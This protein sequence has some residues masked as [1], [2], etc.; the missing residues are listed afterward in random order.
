MLFFR[1]AVA[2]SDFRINKI[3][4]TIQT[5]APAA[6]SLHVEFIHFANLREELNPDEKFRLENLLQYGQMLPQPKTNG[7][8]L[9]TIPRPGTISPWSSKAT[10]IIHNCGIKKI[11][12]IER[13][14][15]WY[16]TC[17]E[18]PTTEII[19]KIKVK[20]HDRMT[21][22]VVGDFKQAEL[23]FDEMEPAQLGHI[24]ILNSGQKAL[25]DANSN[26]GLALSDDEITFLYENFTALQRN[27]TDVELMMFAQANSEHCRHKIFN[28]EWSINSKTMDSSLFEMIRET[29]KS[30]P[31]NILSAY[32]DNAAVTSGYSATRFFPNSVNHHYQT[33]KED[34]NILMKV[35]THNHPTAISPYPGASTGSGGEIR[36]ESAT[37]RGAKPKAGLTGFTVSNLH[38]PDFPQPWEIDNGKPERIVSALEIMLEGPIGGASYNNEFGR[39]ALCGYFRCYEQ[40]WQ[41]IIYGYHKP[42]MLA[43]GYGMIRKQHINKNNIPPSAKI[44]V[45]GGPAMLIGLGGGAASSMASGKSDE[46]LDFASVQRD[47]PEMQR[48]CQEVIDACW[49]LNE[50]NPIISIHDVGAGGL[51]NAL[52]ELVSASE[53]GAAFELRNIPNAETGMSPMEIWCNEA[54]ERYVLAIKPETIEI[55]SQFCKRERAPF[56]IL[57]ETTNDKRLILEDEL[58]DNKPIDIPLS[59]IFGKLPRMK[60]KVTHN[61]SAYAALDANKIDIKEA[62]K[63]IL[64]LPTVAD[65]RFLITISDRT[66]SGLVARDQMVGPWQTPVAD[67]AI[68]SS[69]FDSY[70]GEAM[71]IGERTPLALINASAA[72]RMAIGEAITNISAARIMKLDDIVLSANWMAACDN[73]DQDARLFAA[74]QAVSQLC[75]SL[76]ICIPVGKDS[77]SMNTVW[78]EN[79]QLKRVT[80]PVSLII[81]AIAPVVDVRQNLTPQLK[82]NKGETVLLLIDLGLGKNRI[83]GS[84][85]TQVYNHIGS[86]PPDIDDVENLKIF[87]RGIQILNEM[88][89]LLSYHDRSDGGLFVTLCEMAFTSRSGLDITLDDLGSDIH[90]IVFNEELGAVIQIQKD[91]VE[92]VKEVFRGNDLANH[93][94]EIGTLNQNNI[95][96]ISYHDDIA[97]SEDI[98]ALHRLWSETSFHMQSMR[99]N[100]DCAKE[101]YETFSNNDDPGLS[102]NATFKIDADLP[103]I[104]HQARPPIAILREQGVNGQNEMAAAFDRAGFDCIDVHM[105]DIINGKMTLKNF[106]GL[107]ACGGFSYGDVLGAG[108]GWAKSILYNSKAKNEFQE[109]FQRNDTFGLGVCNGCQMF[110]YLRDMIPGAEYWPDFTRNRSEQ[111]EARLVM[112]EVTDSPSILLEGMTGSL[113]P[114]VVAHGEGQAKFKS[115][116]T[117]NKAHS[118]MRYVDHHGNPADVYPLNP[119]GSPGGVTGFTTHDGRFTIMMPHPERVFLKKQYTWIADD[120][121]HEEGPWMKLFY[122]ASK[123]FNS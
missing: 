51:S 102:I 106:Y 100:P 61:E 43:G 90:S 19:E 32:K 84:A 101:E 81:T 87:F 21:E 114:I 4:S 36:D 62:I 63:R 65:K 105:S 14:T 85:L 39:P 37:G 89:V 82:T 121:T 24:D 28:A 12:R 75:Q 16:L 91:D 95:L 109:F 11:Q 17:N 111:F 56:A 3:F 76:G 10:D 35:E 54:Q 94:H 97:V 80:S 34:V 59:M 9:L 18:N 29:Y 118:V 58:F 72:G 93:V 66:V 48:R 117:I 50:N 104:T 60:R 112:I 15:A 69:S 123:W 55:F 49:G 120:W 5:L 13:G 96:N 99:D 113:L 33:H 44:I 92:T 108:G 98:L 20:I 41:N 23:L 27:P 103:F 70:V 77:L 71:A 119:N 31:G 116:K 2:L 68:T 88:G 83:G 115:E 6:T 46:A 26:M 38:I 73:T 42:I 7:L 25:K 53:R 122:N 45:L 1:G 79:G 52:P 30:N 57:G 22:I 40:N 64:H 78:Q 107:A 47:N 86:E 8:L 67:C 110:S 74:V